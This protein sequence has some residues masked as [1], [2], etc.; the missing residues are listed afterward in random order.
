MAGYGYELAAALRSGKTVLTGWSSLPDAGFVGLLAGAGFDAITLDMQH[1]GHAEQSVWDG[2]AA[3]CAARKPVLVRV[4]VGRFEMASRAL[5][6]G[7]DAV[8]APMIN[9]AEDAEAFA[10]FVKYPPTGQ[11]SWGPTRGITVRGIAGG[12]A[13]L[14]SAN[15]DTLA[16][17]MIETRQALDALDA[18]LDVDCIDG[19]FVGPADFSIA[20]TDGAELDTVLPDMMDAIADIA[21]RAGARGK[22]AGI[23]AADPKMAGRYRQMG[24][25]LIAVGFDGA[26]VRKGAETFLAQARGED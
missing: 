25:G 21:A 2:V 10:A 22:Q 9:S 1:G 17:A 7:A 5:D 13:Y 4:P 6:F 23:F 3:I 11:R 15:T 8:I 19:V 24:Y 16:L 18:I 20:W 14:R 26:L 12:N